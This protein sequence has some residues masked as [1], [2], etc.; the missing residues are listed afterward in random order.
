MKLHATALHLNDWNGD[1]VAADDTYRW[2]IIA[3]GADYRLLAVPHG[4]ERG[5]HFSW[6]YT[7]YERAL[8]AVIVFDPDSEDEPLWW[9]KRQGDLRE[10]PHRDR[11]PRYNRPR[12][13]HGGYRDEPC[14]VN[15]YCPRFSLKDG[16]P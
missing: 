16:V 11:D 7:H 6:R 5:E 2:I 9:Y 12:C 1:E 3:E 14:R 13:G 15:K 8:S 10:A 4:H